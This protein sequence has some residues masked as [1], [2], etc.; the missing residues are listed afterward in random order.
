VAMGAPLVMLLPSLRRLTL[1]GIVTAIVVFGWLMPY[2]A[3]WSTF[4]T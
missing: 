3:E 4:E 2:L 1:P